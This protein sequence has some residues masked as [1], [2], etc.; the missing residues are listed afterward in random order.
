M[1]TPD[2][3]PVQHQVDRLLLEQGE[4]LPLEFL[5]QEGR[6]NYAD[7][8]SW[9]NGELDTLDEAL[10]GDHEHIQQQLTQAADYLQRL[11]WQMETATYQAWRNDH[12]Q[13]LSF[14]QNSAL[15]RCFHQRYHKPQD[16]SQLD[17]FTD[18]PATN[19]VNGTT[20]ALVNRNASEAR[21]QLESL[22][23]TAPDHGRLG[24]LERLVE[25]AENLDAPVIDTAADTQLLQT[26]LT[27]LAES[28]LGKE[29]RNLLTPLWR[30][31]SSAL[32]NQPYQTAQPD[33]HASYT[34]SRAMDWDIARQT[35]EQ[36]PDWQ[37]DPVLLQRHARACD[38]LHLRRDALLS[39][40]NL[41]WRFPQQSDAL[42]SSSDAEL[43]RQWINFLELEPEL[44]A[45]TFPAW[46]LLDK[47]GL[48]RILAAPHNDTTT[49]PASYQTL[50]RLQSNIADPTDEHIALRARLKQQDPVLFQHYLNN[51][52]K[53]P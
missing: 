27:P 44:P 34:A 24:E 17:M 26:T 49:C 47:P 31:L 39:W 14:S 2:S 38:Q 41:C 32:R 35:V 4:Y 12:S 45:Q 30:R 16:Q 20:R 52:R 7:Y 40:F 11:G 18:A 19:L 53:L 42:E 3:Q 6:L 46:L 29:S 22:Y 21:R 28:L 33:M 15:D 13:R 50:Y 36:V 48:T 37:A 8:E 1:S 9:R 43:H 10:F 25:A 51:I 5:L 23:D